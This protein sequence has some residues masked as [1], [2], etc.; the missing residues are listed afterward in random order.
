MKSSHHHYLTPEAVSTY[1]EGEKTKT[2]QNGNTAMNNYVPTPQSIEYCNLLGLLNI[3]V[4]CVPDTTFLKWYICSRH[5][6]ANWPHDQA[7][8]IAFRKLYYVPS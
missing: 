3:H 1:N 8:V 7:T 2:K 5:E 6:L 4:I